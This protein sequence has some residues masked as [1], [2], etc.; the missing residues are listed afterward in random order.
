MKAD[1]LAKHYGSLTP[2]ERLPLIMAAAGRKDD[3]EWERLVSS[4]PT[5]TWILRH[6]FGLSQAF[7]EVSDIH[8]MELLSSAAGYLELMWLSETLEPEDEEPEEKAETPEDDEEVDDGE[9]ES[10]QEFFQDG[11]MYLGY[12]VKAK[13]AGWRLFCAEQRVDPEVVWSHLPGYSLVQRAARMAEDLAFTAEG[14]AR[15]RERKGYSPPL[16]G[17]EVA[18]ALKELLRE[19]AARWK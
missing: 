5:V 19:Q 1:G 10:K 18:A 9:P 17:E 12:L 4:A 2:E 13:L 14:A 11:A 3:A 7:G 16:T 6:H 15:F 8:Y